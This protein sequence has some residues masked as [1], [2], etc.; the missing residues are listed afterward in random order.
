MSENQC[1]DYKLD[2]EIVVF[3]NWVN[4]NLSSVRK[5][6]NNGQKAFLWQC[7]SWHGGE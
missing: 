3:S 2:T 4:K 6:S 7:A 1:Q 5:Y